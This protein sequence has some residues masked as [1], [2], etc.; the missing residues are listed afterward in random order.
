MAVSTNAEDIPKVL[1]QLQ[2]T[3]PLYVNPSRDVIRSWGVED[4]EN[5]I[6]IPATFIVGADGKVRYS[7]IGADKADRPVMKEIMDVLVYLKD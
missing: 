5:E 4:L 3:Y 1:D 6:A 2:V 7:H